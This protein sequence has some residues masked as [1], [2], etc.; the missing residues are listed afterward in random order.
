MIIVRVRRR[1]ITFTRRA[2]Y[3]YDIGNERR[4]IRNRCH[5]QAFQRS[6]LHCERSLRGT[7]ASNVVRGYLGYRKSD[8]I[9]ERHNASRD[10]NAGHFRHEN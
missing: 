10:V 6:F 8:G 7:R 1:E 9:P 4:P 5:E 3:R 2:R